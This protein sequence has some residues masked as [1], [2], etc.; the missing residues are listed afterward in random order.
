MLFLV[1]MRTAFLSLGL[2]A[3]LVCGAGC[4]DSNAPLVPPP[5]K[6]SAAV[7]FGTS[8]TFSVGE[9]ITFQD[10]VVIKL[11]AID[12]SRCPAGVQCIWAGELSPV[13]VFSDADGTSQ[14]FRLGTTRTT[15]VTVKN[16]VIS[17]TGAT[18]DQATITVSK[19]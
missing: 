11:T 5:E 14:E 9:S 1:Y 2:A 12:D 8:A 16:H 18:E 15:Q 4:S 13:F 17:L 3:L 7:P 19:K 6:P 10:G